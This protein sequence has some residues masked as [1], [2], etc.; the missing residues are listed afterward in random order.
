MSD[1]KNI[2][3]IFPHNDSAYISSSKKVKSSSKS[4]KN[5]SCK[6]HETPKSD[7]PF[8]FFS[9]NI[10]REMQR[11]LPNDLQEVLE[12]TKQKYKNQQKQL[13]NDPF[14]SKEEKAEQNKGIQKMYAIEK[15]K[16]SR[17]FEYARNRVLSRREKANRIYEKEKKKM[18]NKMNLTHTSH[19]SQPD[20]DSVK[21]GGFSPD[22][23][24][25][26]T[27]LLDTSLRSILSKKPEKINDTTLNL[28]KSI[29]IN[30]VHKAL[31]EDFSSM[32]IS[33]ESELDD[34]EEDSQDSSQDETLKLQ[35]N[36]LDIAGYD[37]TSV[38]QIFKDEK[39]TENLTKINTHK[40]EK[41][42]DFQSYTT[43]PAD[44]IID[45]DLSR[46]EIGFDSGV[47]ISLNNLS[48]PR[49]S[50]S[51]IRKVLTTDKKKL[52][53]FTLPKMNFKNSNNYHNC[54][55]EETL[56]NA[57]LDLTTATNSSKKSI[58]WHDLEERI[59][60]RDARQKRII[61]EMQEPM[62]IKLFQPL[63]KKN[64]YSDNNTK[65]EMENAFNFVLGLDNPSE[66]E[67]IEREHAML[68]VLAVQFMDGDLL[69]DFESEMVKQ[70]MVDSLTSEIGVQC[71]DINQGRKTNQ[72]ASSV[73]YSSSSSSTTKQEKP[74][75][76]V[77]QKV[78]KH[79][80]AQKEYFKE[81]KQEAQKLAYEEISESESRMINEEIAKKQKRDKEK[82]KQKDK[83]LKSKVEA[84]KIKLANIKSDK[85]KI[86]SDVPI[87][88]EKSRKKL[89]CDRKKKVYRAT[90]NKEKGRSKIVTCKK[91]NRKE[92]HEKI[93]GDS[94]VD[95]LEK[96]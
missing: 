50:D 51:P 94:P 74:L 54:S 65:Q 86:E 45:H 66:A 29:D 53:K 52:E 40:N 70:G 72:N 81:L 18:A 1:N 33:D 43:Q 17:N 67:R 34:D 90:S 3:K 11:P 26:K 5:N 85:K 23:V 31:V 14:L 93:F 22:T 25:I 15:S 39:L 24:K 47:N 80:K 46:V 56:A 83:K 73:S 20:S 87:M 30:K 8:L 28:D 61:K 78:T 91:R 95:E 71:G 60:N 58:K 63:S 32:V 55:V 89:V 37:K 57:N 92:R 41:T 7:R 75:K 38:H 13:Y 36:G 88:R 16:I 27:P 6:S 84:T 77:R 21:G 10:R 48:V 49:S 12:A 76:I 42:H 2:T 64:K 69:K 79:V 19:I 4:D 96:R 62:N 82:Q 44:Q 9:S 59:V 35:K 68:R